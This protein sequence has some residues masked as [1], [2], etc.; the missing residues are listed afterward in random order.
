MTKI[1]FKNGEEKHFKNIKECYMWLL[2]SG[3]DNDDVEKIQDDNKTFGSVAEFFIHV[4]LN[5]TFYKS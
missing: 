5:H 1:V 3:V 4:V 2:Q